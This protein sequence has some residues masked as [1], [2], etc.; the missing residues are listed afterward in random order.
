[1]DEV[2]KALADRH[3]RLLLDRLN[4]RNGQTLHELCADLAMSR[5]AVS[6]HLAVLEGALLVTTLRQGREKLHYLNAA[7]IHEIADRW[8]HRYDRARVEALA[9]LKRALETPTMDKPEFVYTTYIRTTPERLWAALTE[10]AFTR[11]YWD[12]E[13]ESDWKVGATMAW[14]H[15]DVVV[16]DPE[17]IVLECSPPRRLSYTWHTFSEEWAESYGVDEETRARIAAERR[18]RVTFVLEPDGPRVKLTVVHDGFEPGSTVLDMISGGWP[19]VVGDLKTLLEAGGP[20]DDGFAARVVVDAPV[21]TVAAA[22]TTLDGLAS[23]WTTDV[24][25][26]PAALGGEVTFGFDDERVRMRV[27]HID[28]TLVVWNCLASER[29]PEWAGT[30]VWFD[31]RPRDDGTVAVDFRHVGL[32][33]SCDCYGVCSGAWRHYLEN[34]RTVVEGG[35][36]SPYGSP[37]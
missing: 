30:S 3:R 28:P 15:D 23:W 24:T 20:D 11:R 16:R 8:I 14:G 33:P 21:E 22:L 5:Q 1:V 31:L 7:P 35:A 19:R 34:L 29:F 25:G 37:R 18:S 26:V 10:P 12:T 17:Q 2:F 27:E 9:D 32:L 6:K 13:L 4:E 36:G